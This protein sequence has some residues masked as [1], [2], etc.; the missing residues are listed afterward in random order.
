MA[1]NADHGK[2]H[3]R[4]VRVRVPN[5]D[6]GG[7][8]VEAKERQGSSYERKHD[9]SGEEM[10]AIAIGPAPDLVQVH[11]EDCTRNNDLY[12]RNNIYVVSCLCAFVGARACMCV[13]GVAIDV[14]GGKRKNENDSPPSHSSTQSSL[15]TYALPCLEPIYSGQDVDRVG[16]NKA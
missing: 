7:E 2:G 16:T 4:K 15:S 5:E 3:P 13:F 11:A 12:V 10:V 8:P 9:S 14:A 1:E 6:R